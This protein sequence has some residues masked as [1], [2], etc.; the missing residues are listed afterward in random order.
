MAYDKQKLE[1]MNRAFR[2]ELQLN[3][4]PIPVHQFEHGGALEDDEI[5]YYRD[6]T[7]QEQDKMIR[8]GEAEGM[9]A[10]LCEAI[11]IR[12]VD[13][14]GRALF[15]EAQRPL[16]KKMN[17]RFVYAIGNVMKP[18]DDVNPTPEDAKKNSPSTP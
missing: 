2:E 1:Q 6:S 4:K 5:W 14:D 16:I 8:I 12:C 17:P 9:F 10:G 15:A 7:G 11:L 3:I 13:E 18:F